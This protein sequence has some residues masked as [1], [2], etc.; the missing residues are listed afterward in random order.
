MWWQVKMRSQ[1][2][3]GLAWCL[4]WIDNST[5]ERL[6]PVLN[7]CPSLSQ[8]FQRH[9][10][11]FSKDKESNKDDNLVS[12]YSMR[13]SVNS[14]MFLLNGA[15][16]ASLQKQ[17][18]VPFVCHCQWWRKFLY[19]GFVSICQHCHQSESQFCFHFPPLIWIRGAKDSLGKPRSSS[20]QLPPPAPLAEH[21]GW[22]GN[23]VPPGCRGS[24][25]LWITSPG[26]HLWE[27]PSHALIMLFW[28]T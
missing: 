2:S 26:R 3:N 14:D 8:T 27:S 11:N 25:G 22:V 18:L 23:V 21:Q 6:T 5:A 10:N 9:F 13:Q 16:D 20:S 15:S 24:W 7:V 17:T 12:E 1:T 4:E 28:S 19:V